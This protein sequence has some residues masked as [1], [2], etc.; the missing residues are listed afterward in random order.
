MSEEQQANQQ[1]AENREEG[2]QEK[3]LAFSDYADKINE[4]IIKTY[5]SITEDKNVKDKTRAFDAYQ[6]EMREDER[7][8]ILKDLEAVKDN[9]L[10]CLKIFAKNGEYFMRESSYGDYIMN[11]GF[12]GMKK[13]KAEKSRVQELQKQEVETK[14]EATQTPRSLPFNL[15]SSGGQPTNTNPIKDGADP[16]LSRLVPGF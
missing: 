5:E 4:D 2:K 16:Y 1:T 14:K 7:E 10:A 15:G 13:N 12:R 11:G 9:P 8:K 3:P 6:W